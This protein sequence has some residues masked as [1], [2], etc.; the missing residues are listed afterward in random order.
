MKKIG[1]CNNKGDVGKTTVCF[2]L[3]GSLAGMGKKVL[4]VDMDQQ[5]SLS[6]SF[7][8]CVVTDILLDGK[9]PMT[10]CI[11]KTQFGV[12]DVAPANL[13]LG[14]IEAELL[15]ERDPHYYLADKVEAIE[16]D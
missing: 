16:G 14:R 9:R 13:S 3:A 7:R 1:I 10:D 4:V 15:S 5:G 2:C 12:I 11:H 8:P 6:S